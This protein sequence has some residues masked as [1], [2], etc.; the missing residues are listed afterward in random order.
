EEYLSEQAFLNG[1]AW[2]FSLDSSMQYWQDVELYAL[3]H[4]KIKNVEITVTPPVCGTSTV[5]QEIE[6]EWTQTNRPQFSVNDDQKYEAP[7]DGFWLNASSFEEVDAISDEGG[8]PLLSCTFGGG[9]KYNAGLFLQAKWGY[10]FDRNTTTFTVN[11]G[12]VIDNIYHRYSSG[13]WDYQ[14]EILT[15]VAVEHNWN[16]GTVTKE[17]TVS[18]EGIREYKCSGCGDVRTETIPKLVPSIQTIGNCHW[19]IQSSVSFDRNVEGAHHYSVQVSYHNGDQVIY[20]ET[21]NQSTWLSFTNQH[22]AGIYGFTVKAYDEAGN[23][24]AEGSCDPTP[25]Y[26]VQCRFTTLDDDGNP[27]SVTARGNL[28]QVIDSQYAGG[29]SVSNGSHF[30]VPAGDYRLSIDTST[31][32]GSSGYYC[33]DIR[34]INDGNQ[35]NPIISNDYSIDFTAGDSLTI[36]VN[37]R[38]TSERVPIN[39]VLGEKGSPYASAIRDS[40]NAL[41][42]SAHAAVSIN[43]KAVGWLVLKS[44]TFGDLQDMLYR[45]ASRV[46]GLDEN[47]ALQGIGLKPVEQCKSWADCY[48]EN[49]YQSRVSAGQSFY[50]L[51][52]NP[53][54]SVSADLTA[55][56]P[57]CGTSVTYYNA[58]VKILSEK[59]VNCEIQTMLWFENERLYPYS[60]TIEGGS[61]YRLGIN[62]RPVFGQYFDDNTKFSVKVNGTA[63][64][65]N[66][67]AEEGKLFLASFT[68]DHAWDAGT[69]TKAA[70][71]AADGEKKFT[72]TICG[73]T[74]TEK[75]PKT[76]SKGEDGTAFG[77]GASLEVA[78]AAIIGLTNDKDPVGAKF[79]ILQLKA[80]KTTKNSI[81][82]TWKK[83]SGAKKYIIY[84]N[85][86]GK[87]KKYQ[88]LMTSAKTSATIKKVAGAKLKKGTY[89]KFMM[90]AVDA[91]NKVI[92]TSTVVHAATAGGKVGNPT[93]ITTKAKKNKVTVKVKKTFKLAAKQAGKKIKK[94]R[95]VS[96]ET[97]NAAIAVVSK[98][99]VIKG[100]KKGKCFVYVYAQN[101]A[102]QKINVTVK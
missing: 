52:F 97:S 22:G 68:A 1:K 95:A 96:Y 72:C 28:W 62:I 17:P 54:A 14:I 102:A 44:M 63:A 6:W 19:G 29:I 55:A 36:E 11:G 90:V 51:W 21:A 37:V 24:I 93:K 9:N 25:L 34:I 43:G 61:P 79:G 78:E 98:K 16:N 67:E 18:E 38:K 75:I 74:R 46:D 2:R 73:K 5:G 3:W 100:L 60:G 86:C 32:P 88:K 70:T 50:C 53:A 92:S 40:I 8:S 23:L 82:L 4:E 42:P 13:A 87:G 35:A 48:P 20:S 71:A 64:S 99:G 76:A 47:A 56:A 45:V 84:A 85:A 58:Q 94:H 7:E 65:M 91:S 12:T 101:G 66:D 31:L 27:V 59:L 10:C 77:K 83:A 30:L 81:K 89:Y 39:L 15:A 49:P 80:A 33:Q 26:N 41:D 69:V 57:V